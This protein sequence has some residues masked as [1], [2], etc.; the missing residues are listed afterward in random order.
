MQ[1]IGL[2]RFSYLGLGGFQVRHDSLED[3]AAYLYAPHR[4]EQRFRTFE[5]ITLPP[6]RAQT[7]PDFTLLIVTGESLPGPYYSR[8][9]AL[10]G[11]MPQVVVQK[12]PPDDHRKRM[13]KA[14]N[15]VRQ[16]DPAP[17]AQ[18]R[19]DDDDAVACSYVEKLRQAMRDVA[20]L[21][22]KER[23]IAIDFNTGFVAR[24]G[25]DGLYTSQ[26][27]NA[28]SSAALA[29]IFRREV[30]QSVMNFSHMSVGRDM[31]TVTFTGEPMLIRGRN[32][33]NDSRQNAGTMP[34]KLTL[35]S[36]EE[37][38]HFKQV[39]NIDANHVR[40]VFSAA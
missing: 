16:F 38:L 15:S 7:D 9:M 40:Q 23:H 3:R 11:D 34:I 5:T 37:E 32:D 6:L 29:I 18:F 10:V 27:N 28:Y 13:R 17:C 39:F 30:S 19:M 36:P 20:G 25:V 8:L 33:Y 14:I 24:P 35:Q 1:I 31:P 12:H 26:V 22:K 21:I 4:M 2:C